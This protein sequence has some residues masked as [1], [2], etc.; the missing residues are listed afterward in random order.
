MFDNKYLLE[1][2]NDMTDRTA[3]IQKYLDTYGVCIL[4]AGLYVVNGVDY[5]EKIGNNVSDS[6]ASDEHPVVTPGWDEIGEGAPAT[7]DTLSLALLCLIV[8]GAAT[9]ITAKGV[10]SERKSR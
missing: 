9:V 4:G 2:T 5:T 3:E 1:S 6:Y 10:L 7:Q 8:C